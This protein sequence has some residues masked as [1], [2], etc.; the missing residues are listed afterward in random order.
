MRRRTYV[1]R[2]VE[3]NAALYYNEQE[4]RLEAVEGL[5]GCLHHYDWPEDREEEEEWSRLRKRL[6]RQTREK[7]DGTIK[8]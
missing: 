6:E 2:C 7:E 4:E 5:P 8:S 1:G 3:C